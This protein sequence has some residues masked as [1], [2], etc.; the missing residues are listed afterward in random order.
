VSQ[1]LKADSSVSAEFK[2]ASKFAFSLL[3]RVA[4]KGRSVLQT[5]MPFD[6]L[7]FLREN[8]SLLLHDIGEI[9]VSVEASVD[10]SGAAVPGSP[11]LRF[12]FEE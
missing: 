4:T 9:K 8:V 2:R 7:E 12:T 5:M 10:G 11:A 3:D 6:E 1:A